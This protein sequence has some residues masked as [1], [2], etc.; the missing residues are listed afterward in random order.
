[1]QRHRPYTGIRQFGCSPL[2]PETEGPR[3]QLS[4]ALGGI[5]NAAEAWYAP[6]EPGSGGATE[7]LLS[8]LF[9][10]SN[11]NSVATA[12]L[13]QRQASSSMGGNT[14]IG[15]MMGSGGMSIDAGQLVDTV[16][17]SEAVP[18]P[19]VYVGAAGADQRALHFHHG[20]SDAHSPQ[21]L[22]ADRLPAQQWWGGCGRGQRAA[23]LAG[24]AGWN[25]AGHGAIGAS[26]TAVA[27]PPPPSP[28]VPSPYGMQPT[29]IP[30]WQWPNWSIL[31]ALQQQQQ[32]QESQQPVAY[33]RQLNPRLFAPPPPPPVAAQPSPLTRQRGGDPHVDLILSE[34]ALGSNEARNGYAIP[35][36]PLRMPPSWGV[37]FTATA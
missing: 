31:G 14:S 33:C 8:S 5:T 27:Q 20:R 1:M 16:G 17:P 4:S 18:Q 37:D 28:V 9:D 35:A 23:A 22:H 12:P 6:M 34:A 19:L 30:A 10:L 26:V 25:G 36:P 32:Q 29:G 2:F 7:S 3:L 13:S 11:G 15:S 24:V 21:P